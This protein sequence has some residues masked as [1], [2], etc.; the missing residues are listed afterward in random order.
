[1]ANQRHD[2]RTFER[3]A[4]VWPIGELIFDTDEGALYQGD[5][6]SLGGIRVAEAAELDRALLGS[7]GYE[8]TGGFTDRDS[9]Q[10]GAN[11]I[12]GSVS[13]TADMAAAGQWYRF[14]FDATRQAALQAAAAEGGADLQSMQRD[15]DPEA[16]TAQG[17]SREPGQEVE[18]GE[19]GVHHP[20]LLTAGEGAEGP[21]VHGEGQQ[22]PQ[23]PDGRQA[24]GGPRGADKKKGAWSSLKEDG[25]YLVIRR[26]SPRSI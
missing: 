19:V 16:R 4:R 5:N 20:H 14:G 12:G 18:P 26:C 22:I 21:Q 10:S 13:Y 23:G 3:M 8:F 11:E 24:P 6:L 17:A 2:Y 9:G 1:M 25:S 7:S 15:H